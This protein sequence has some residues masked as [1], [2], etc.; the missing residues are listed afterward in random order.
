MLALTVTC[1]VPTVLIDKLL[2]VAV[3]SIVFVVICKSLLTLIFDWYTTAFTPDGTRLIV[4]DVLAIVLPVTVKV[5]MSACVCT[6]KFVVLVVPETLSSFVG[7]FVL[8]PTR[9]FITSKKSKS[10]S[11]AKFTPSRSKLSFKSGPE[12]RPTAICAP[13]YPVFHG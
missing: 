4:P 11:K 9:P 1:P 8:M 13:E 12:I 7:I 6:S 5:A 3:V 2:L 10:V